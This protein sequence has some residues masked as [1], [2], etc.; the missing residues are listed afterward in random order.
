MQWTDDIDRV[1]EYQK[2]ALQPKPKSTYLKK[3]SWVIIAITILLI[4][5]TLLVIFN[6]TL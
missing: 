4:V 1:V 6:Q 3:M 2:K 5:T